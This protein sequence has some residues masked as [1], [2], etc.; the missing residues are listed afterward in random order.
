MISR[1]ELTS[2]L[3]DTTNPIFPKFTNASS[4]SITSTF[5]TDNAATTIAIPAAYIYGFS[6]SLTNLFIVGVNQQTKKMYKVAL[7]AANL[8]ASGITYDAS[9]WDLGYYRIYIRKYTASTTVLEYQELSTAP[10]YFNRSPLRFMVYVAPGEFMMGAPANE[11]G[12]GG[13]SN[14]HL[15][16]LTTGF[17]IGRTLLTNRFFR[18]ITGVTGTS[19]N[20]S[21]KNYMC[22]SRF[23]GYGQYGKSVKVGG[24]DTWVTTYY[25]GLGQ[26]VPN[27][28]V[29]GT[30]FET[31]ATLNTQSNGS[32][33]L[34]NSSVK[35][36]S[37]GTVQATT[38]NGVIDLMNAESNL[39]VSGYNWD[40]PT[41]A[42]WEYAC[43]AGTKTA[44]NNGTNLKHPT[45][46][47]GEG[48]SDDT[49]QPNVDQVAWY[50][51]HGNT[52]KT[53]GLLLPNQWGL[54][55]MHGNLYEWCKDWYNASYGTTSLV[56]P[57]VDP[58]NNT[59]A[60]SRVLRGGYYSSPA[61]ACRSANRN[62]GYPYYAYAYFGGRLALV[63]ASS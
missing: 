20:D 31:F 33:Y 19:A 42:Q 17:F 21:P 41:E 34:V 44:F 47:T 10:L 54:Y 62:N 8:S 51:Q 23:N 37:N 26:D 48:G 3:S 43:R 15:V 49:V 1:V 58:F 11:Y 6:A 16:K 4:P 22:Y 45:A 53:C 13:S 27:A 40:L 18:A 9:G 28:D 35:D 39:A 24:K 50:K 60:S 2:S 36:S 46:A 63:P 32:C 30:K 38:E 61:R 29:S 5:L 57:L 52:I 56:T 7:A 25:S 12:A 14:L 59:V 55:D